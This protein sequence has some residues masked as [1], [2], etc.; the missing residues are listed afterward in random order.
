MADRSENNKQNKH[1]QRR[2][3][4]AVSARLETTELA[5]REYNFDTVI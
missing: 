5:N 2:N 1:E 3:V 4:D